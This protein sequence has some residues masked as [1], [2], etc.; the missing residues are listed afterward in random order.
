M[1][2]QV[3]VNTPGFSYQQYNVNTSVGECFS[4]KQE[5]N[6]SWIQDDEESV[7]ICPR[8][9]KQQRTEITQ[10]IADENLDDNDSEDS[11]SDSSTIRKLDNMILGKHDGNSSDEESLGDDEVPRG[12]K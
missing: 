3:T 10:G 6:E 4:M 7:D 8:P 11:N 12:W 9:S 1:Q 2:Q 5:M